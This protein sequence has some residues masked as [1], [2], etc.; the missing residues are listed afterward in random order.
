[1]FQFFIHVQA[2]VQKHIPY[3]H[4]NAP[5]VVSLHGT[6]S[7]RNW[8]NFQRER[9]SATVIQIFLRMFAHMEC[10]N[11]QKKTFFFFHAQI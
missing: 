2:S 1:M 10:V 6:C 7:F 5:N 4:T 3:I 8:L 9:I 11:Y